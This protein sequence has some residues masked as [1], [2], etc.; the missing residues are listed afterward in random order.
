MYWDER[1]ATYGP[2][3]DQHTLASTLRKHDISVAIGAKDPWNA[4]N[5]RFD[6]GWNMVQGNMTFEEAYEMGS[7]TLERLL[8]VRYVEDDQSDL[9]VYEAGHA[10]ELSAKPIA[11]ISPTLGHVHIL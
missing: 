7:A 4:R 3:V 1:R 5:L 9:V 10:L 6:I 2:P 8:G 11:V